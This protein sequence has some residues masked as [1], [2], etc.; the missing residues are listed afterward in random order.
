MNP[1]E[2]IHR[3][4]LILDMLSQPYPIPLDEDFKRDREERVERIK[5]RLKEL[6]KPRW[7][8]QL[9]KRLLGG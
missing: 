6:E 8:E 3:L 9:F 4:K 7:Y 5:T 1:Q 2:E